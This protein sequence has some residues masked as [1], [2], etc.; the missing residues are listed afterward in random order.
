[1]IAYNSMAHVEDLG[2][3]LTAIRELMDD[4]SVAVFEVQYLPDMIAGNM[5]DSVYHEHRFFYS[6]GSLRRAAALNGL[7]VVDAELIELQNGGLRVTLST[8]QW[9]DCHVSVPMIEGAEK[10]LDRFS[11]FQGIINRTRDHLIQLIY[12]QLA[13]GKTLGGYGAAAKATTILN[14]CQMGPGTVPFVVDTTVYKQGRFVPGTGI[15][16]IAPEDAEEVDLILLLAANYLGPVMRNH[17]H[18][19]S[20]IAPLPVPQVI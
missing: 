13:A 14:F 9:L 20:W 2:D 10:W 17:P 4:E 12:Q 3:V 19:G 6:L 15:P 5:Y 7:Y 11:G 18:K 8:D 16:I 1:V